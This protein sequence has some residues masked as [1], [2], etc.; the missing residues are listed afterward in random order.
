[1][2][3][4]QA[5]IAYE[6][7]T[8]D[9]VIFLAGGITGVANWQRDALRLILRETPAQAPVVVL[10]PRQSQFDVANKDA[11]GAQIRWEVEHLQ[12]ANVTLFW[13]PAC[14]PRVTVQPIALFELGMAL[15]DHRCWGRGLVVGADPDYPRRTDIVEQCSNWLGPGFTVHDGLEATVKAAVAMVMW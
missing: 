12:R 15:G 9:R 3:V 10:D 4:V 5:P 11:A 6:R 13:F 7:E 2:K 8:D 14:D 1:M